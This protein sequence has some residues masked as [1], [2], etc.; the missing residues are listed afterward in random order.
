MRLFIRERYSSST[1]F[2]N[3]ELEAKCIIHSSGRLIEFVSGPPKPLKPHVV[4]RLKKK[5]EQYNITGTELAIR[6]VAD[7]AIEIK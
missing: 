1:V 4:Y 6:M 2:H 7:N 3:R 5:D